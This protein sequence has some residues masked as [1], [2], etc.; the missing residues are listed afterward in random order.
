VSA[1]DLEM[2]AIKYRQS[3]SVL[4]TVADICNYCIADICKRMVDVCKRLADICS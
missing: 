1:N 2:S 3:I 4:H